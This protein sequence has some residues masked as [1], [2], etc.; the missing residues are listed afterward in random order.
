M[1]H[2]QIPISGVNTKDK[3]G[4]ARKAGTPI[5]VD[6]KLGQTQP[7][8]FTFLSNNINPHVRKNL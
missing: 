2:A 5:T 7:L 8:S 1:I 3:K 4:R 6:Q